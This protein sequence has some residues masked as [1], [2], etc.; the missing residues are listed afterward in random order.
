MENIPDTLTCEIEITPEM[1]EAGVAALEDGYLYEDHLSPISLPE[2]VQH[3]FRQMTRAK[4]SQSDGVG[5][6]DNHDG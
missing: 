3:V 4:T 2:A 6:R 5:V 1:I